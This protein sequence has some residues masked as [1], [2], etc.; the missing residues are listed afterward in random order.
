MC[1]KNTPVGKSNAK[2]QASLLHATVPWNYIPGR[3]AAALQ[4]VC[5]S[6]LSLAPVFLVSILF[7]FAFYIPFYYISIYG[8]DF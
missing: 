4:S 2:P 5:E 7:K 8:T 3:L 1:K 6:G